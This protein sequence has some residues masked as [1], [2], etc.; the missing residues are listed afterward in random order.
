MGALYMEVYTLHP[1]LQCPMAKT[2]SPRVGLSCP[3]SVRVG[4][5]R[6]DGW[7]DMFIKQ[8]ISTFNFD[9]LSYVTL[10]GSRTT[11]DRRHFG[12]S[13]AHLK[14]DRYP[15]WVRAPLITGSTSRIRPPSP[16]NLRTGRKGSRIPHAFHEE[17]RCFLQVGTWLGPSCTSWPSRR[18]GPK[19]HG[20][21]GPMTKQTISVDNTKRGTSLVWK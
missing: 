12:K 1:P 5:L 15:I 17:F 10:K 2:C 3:S 20:R 6:L 18:Q 19:P 4:G 11:P 21:G 9:N 8:V 14:G 16:E 7:F 13:S